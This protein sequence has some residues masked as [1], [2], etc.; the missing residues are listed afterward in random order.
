MAVS[1]VLRRLASKQ[2]IEGRFSFQTVYYNTPYSYKCCQCAF[3]HEYVQ[4]IANDGTVDLK[5]YDLIEQS[6]IT[7][8]CPHVADVPSKGARE[9]KVNAIQ[10]AVA[11]NS[12]EVVS[13]YNQYLFWYL[14]TTIFQLTPFHLAVAR[15]KSE[16]VGIALDYLLELAQMNACNLTYVNKIIFAYR[17]GHQENLI[18]SFIPITVLC[19]RYKMK[20]MLRRILHPLV[21]HSDVDEAL[22]L[23]FR[24]DDQD[25]Q[26][27]I[28]E[29]LYHMSKASKYD[30]ILDCAIC[31]ILYNQPRF[32]QK[33][34]ELLYSSN[35]PMSRFQG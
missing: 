18:I 20:H 8:R 9:T 3:I 13:R 21:V 4:Y 26:E 34:F 28:L 10:I 27:D 31:S 15:D 19:L 1:D 25:S 35:I 24:N 6:I 22:A 5:Q 16:I 2:Y 11:S 12:I 32:L 7:G 14:P 23:S 17:D 33:V 29:Y 30:L